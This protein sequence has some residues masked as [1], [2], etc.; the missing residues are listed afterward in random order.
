MD[1]NELP[2]LCIPCDTLEHLK[3]LVDTLYEKEILT[4]E[5]IIFQNCPP[6]ILQI[7]NRS[8]FFVPVEIAG[9]KA[10]KGQTEQLNEDLL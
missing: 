4:E 2:S 8:D 1:L 10:V 9:I 3:E 5:T 7:L 6:N